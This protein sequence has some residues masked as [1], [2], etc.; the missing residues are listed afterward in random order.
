MHESLAVPLLVDTFITFDMIH[1][2][3][4]P[5]P[6]IQNG[7]IMKKLL[8]LLISVFYLTSAAATQSQE[9]SSTIVVVNKNNPSYDKVILD[10]LSL[11]KSLIVNPSEIPEPFMQTGFLLVPMTPEYVASLLEKKEGQIICAYHNQTLLGYIILTIATEFE[12]LYQDARTGRFATDIDLSDLH[13]WLSD[14]SVG[15]IEQIGV[16]HGYS[17]MR[18]GSRLIQTSKTLKPHGLIG[19]IFIYPVQNTPSVS[20]FYSQGF[21]SPGILYQYPG[22]NANFPYEHRTKV[23][24]WRG[25]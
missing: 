11:Q 15:Y 22:A 24:F 6:P 13:H 19:D 8:L 9:L 7:D 18:I 25:S 14:P 3:K 1:F 23:F 21:T 4:I 2:F 5:S 16:R 17:R 12:E 10:L 20:F